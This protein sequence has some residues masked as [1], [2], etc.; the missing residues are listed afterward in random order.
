MVAG[1]PSSQY[2]LFSSGCIKIGSIIDILSVSDRY[3]FDNELTIV[4]VIDYPEIAATYSIPLP[5]FQFFYTVRSWV[6]GK[7]VN[8]L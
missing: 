8:G 2:F 4:N 1:K 3:N 5:T 6:F 7:T